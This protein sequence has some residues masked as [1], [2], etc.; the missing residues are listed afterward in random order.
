MSVKQLT[1]LMREKVN[2]AKMQRA[3][4]R[5][6]GNEVSLA[7]SVKTELTAR[8]IK[9]TPELLELQKDLLWL[10]STRS[11]ARQTKR[12]S[13][14]VSASQMK[15]AA[16]DAIDYPEGKPDSVTTPPPPS[17]S[18]TGSAP[19]KMDLESPAETAALVASLLEHQDF[20]RAQKQNAIAAGSHVPDHRREKLDSD[21]SRV[22][23]IL[24]DHIEGKKPPLPPRFVSERIT[25]CLPLNSSLQR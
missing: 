11:S 16:Q 23:S 9:S 1:D 25:F 5:I 19:G 10:T 6:A 2:E 4:G 8:G 7:N 20:L 12:A 21:I 15:R 24:S 18:G 3:G 14:G 13:K 17:A 22:T